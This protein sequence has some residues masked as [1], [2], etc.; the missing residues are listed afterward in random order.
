LSINSTAIYVTD[1]STL[2]GYAG[3]SASALTV[4][5]RPGVYMAGDFLGNGRFFNLNIGLTRMGPNQTL[6][7]PTP[8]DQL[9]DNTDDFLTLLADPDGQYLEYDLPDG[10][11]R[12]ILARA[13][14]PAP[15]FQPRRSRT[16]SVPL[17]GDWPYWSAG[18]AQ[19]SQVING[20]DVL[21]NTGRVPVY[22][23][24]MVFAGDGTFTH[25]EWAIE[26]TGSSGAVTVNLGT[27]T[28][29]QAGVDAE[30]LVRRTNRD[31]G[32]FNAGNNS[33]Q[34]DVSVTV[35]W[36]RQFV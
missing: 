33:V 4:N 11:K 9:W 30:N 17:I 10:S 24:V 23:P 21:N 25:P 27:R 12:F 13:I 6:L 26:V 14:D 22:N 15:I 35:T 32:W 29:T 18:G 8:E 20:V 1:W 3:F 19:N 36:R 5:G 34:S 7:M 2:F 16:I 28:I 31:W